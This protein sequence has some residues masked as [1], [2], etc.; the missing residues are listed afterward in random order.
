METFALSLYLLQQLGIALG[1]V[2]STFAVTFY[3][4]GMA[5]R[6]LDS[7]ERK[8]LNIVKSA[9]TYGL[10]CIIGSGLLITSA[11]LLAE[12]AVVFAP[13]YIF[14][15]LLIMFIVLVTTAGHFD[16][17]PEDVSG[18]I[19]G[20]TW[21]ALY[22]LHILAVDVGWAVLFGFFVAWLA[23]FSMLFVLLRKAVTRRYERNSLVA[24]ERVLPQ[25][26][27]PPIPSIPTPPPQSTTHA[28][29]GFSLPELKGPSQQIETNK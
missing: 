17:L 12:D 11:H 28:A 16:F 18:A 25:R 8:F 21:F 15:W 24:E 27:S 19:N 3:I 29:V 23:L 10:I 22:I 6:S 2:A 5:D 9:R 4:A 26:V 20:G 1:V 14:K 13:A 7:S